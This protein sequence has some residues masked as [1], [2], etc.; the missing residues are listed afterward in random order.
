[1]LKFFSVVLGLFAMIL[2]ASDSDETSETT[3]ILSTCFSCPGTTGSREVSRMSD[4]PHPNVDDPGRKEVLHSFSIH[5]VHDEPGCVTLR[6]VLKFKYHESII[7]DAFG[8][9]KPDAS[10]VKEYGTARRLFPYCIFNATGETPVSWTYQNVGGQVMERIELF[11]SVTFVCYNRY[12]PFCL[13]VLPLKIGTDGTAKTGLINLRPETKPGS[14]IPNVDFDIFTKE[15]SKLSVGDRETALQNNVIC[16]MFVRDLSSNTLGNVAGIYTRVYTV[17]FFESAPADSLLKYVV[18]SSLLM[19]LTSFLPLMDIGDIFSTGLTCALA[20]VAL[21][22]TID[23]DGLCTAELIIIAQI[24]YELL[25]VVALA[26]MHRAGF[27]EDGDVGEGAVDT[28]DLCM[29]LTGVVCAVT[30]IVVLKDYC[31]YRRLV[32]SIKSKFEH[33]KGVGSFTDVDK[34]I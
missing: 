17:F 24:A 11:A 29:K 3:P 6:L 5:S 19:C 30:S 15:T 32:T 18:V 4:A 16:G 7:E 33:G 34:L 1:M 31:A 23:V 14:E 2:R 9:A 21:L 26:I 22:F 12:Y 13:T 10:I 25:M 8:C 20:Q 28:A 27:L